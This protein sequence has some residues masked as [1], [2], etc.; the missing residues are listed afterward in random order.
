MS[1]AS[2]DIFDR[3]RTSVKFVNKNSGDLV[4]ID[5][6]AIE[7]FVYD[8][9]HERLSKLKGTGATNLP[10]NFS[11]EDQHINFLFL[12]NILNFGSG[13]RKQLHDKVKK[14][15]LVSISSTFFI[16]ISFHFISFDFI[17]YFILFYFSFFYFL[18]FIFVFIL[19][20]SDGQR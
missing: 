15:S 14:T 3:I 6:E 7:Q 8:L 1:F 5:L 20:C 2:E 16:V 9:D 19:S 18:F 10:L 12:L 11:S 4:H 13:F 17:F